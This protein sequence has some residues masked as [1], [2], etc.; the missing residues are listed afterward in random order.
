VADASAAARAAELR[1]FLRARDVDATVEV[2]GRATVG[3]SQETWF[4]RLGGD[5]VGSPREVVLR[6]PTQASG[7]RAIVAQRT[8][9]QAVAGSAVPAPALLWFDDA[10]DNAFGRPV[11]VMERVPGTVPVG[12]H[13][14]PGEVRGALAEQAVEILAALH[15][16][17]PS[18]L[19]ALSVEGRSAP[20]ELGFYTRML[21]RYEPLP[22]VLRAG[23]WWLERHREEGLARSAFVHGDFRMGNLMVLGDRITGVLDWEMASPGDPLADLSWCFIPVWELPGVDE[24]GLIRR[25]AQ[26]AGV[27]LDP[28]RLRWHRVLGYVRLAYYVL[29]AARA[30]DAGTSDDLRLAAL[31]LA[32]PAHLDRLAA[33]LAGEAPR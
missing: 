17:D 4:A 32:L 25:Y 20:T 10:A 5:A 8:A 28:E 27:D 2:T 19:A 21:A 31:R 33:T 30:F 22:P 23:L 14:V 9:L 3:L 24:G 11:L 29:S 12:W 7:A 15:A 6:L 16:V 13:A 26:L 1:A 18:P